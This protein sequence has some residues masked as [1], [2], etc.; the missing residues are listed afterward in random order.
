MNDQELIKAGLSMNFALLHL[1]KDNK[2]VLIFAYI[3]ICS[4]THLQILSR[5]YHFL[6]HW[7]RRSSAY[8]TLN[9]VFNNSILETWNFKDYGFLGIITTLVKPR[10]TRYKDQIKL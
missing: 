2:N 6:D 4:L 7:N 10:G 8:V 1:A 3:K 9:P 5:H